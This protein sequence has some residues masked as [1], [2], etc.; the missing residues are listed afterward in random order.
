[1]V[2]F[3]NSMN[4]LRSALLT[5][6]GFVALAPV[7]RAQDAAWFQ[8]LTRE[9]VIALLAA[10]QRPWLEYLERSQRLFAEEKLFRAA[11]AR[12]AGLGEMK[13]AP[14]AAVFGV[15]LNQPVEWFATP[16]GRR[17]T[18]NVLSYQTP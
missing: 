8:P 10:E 2:S 1:M 16:E 7:L 5:L 4:V 11:E 18:A 12:A 6:I 14:Y 3:S 9:R 17:I 15:N 13:L